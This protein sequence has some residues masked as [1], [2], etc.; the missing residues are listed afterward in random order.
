MTTTTYSTSP[1][2]NHIA[3]I[4]ERDGERIGHVTMRGTKFVASRKQGTADDMRRYATGFRTAEAAAKW[5]A[6]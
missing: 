5:I 6:R 1:R 2:R 4:V 3:A